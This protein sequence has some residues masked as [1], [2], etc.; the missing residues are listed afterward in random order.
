MDKSNLNDVLHL[1][2][3]DE[4]G[5]KVRLFREFDPDPGDY[6]VP[7]PYHGGR[8][9]FEN[10]YDI[11]ERTSDMLL[12]RLVAIL[13]KQRAAPGLHAAGVGDTATPDGRH[14]FDRDVEAGLDLALKGVRDHG[15]V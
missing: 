15:G 14:R 1:D 6:Q 7:D 3:D 10:V 13:Q 12:H 5:G 4:H 11:V 8:E 2:E 9:G